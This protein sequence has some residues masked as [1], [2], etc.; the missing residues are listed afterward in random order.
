MSDGFNSD[1]VAHFPLG[2]IRRRNDVRDAVH[3]GIVGRQ[4]RQDAAE[5]VIVIEGEIVRHQE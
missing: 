2:P 3:S 1:Q 5:Q 4:F